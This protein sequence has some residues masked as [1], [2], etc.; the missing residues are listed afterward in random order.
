VES[1]G[2]L[3]QGRRGGGHTIGGGADCVG[4]LAV[5]PVGEQ[6]GVA[7][8]SA[9]Q[10]RAIAGWRSS[11]TTPT[12]STPE[13]ARLLGCSLA[14]AKIRIH[15]ARRRLRPALQAACVFA[16]DEQGVLVGEPDAQAPPAAQLPEVRR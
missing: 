15:R 4:S 1:L 14:T 8:G 6:R 7:V 11:C 12:G 16:A 13:I 3:D 2:A 5:L 10:A 9:F